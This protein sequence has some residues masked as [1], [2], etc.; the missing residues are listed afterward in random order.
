M[1]QTEGELD[2]VHNKKNVFDF[3]ELEE[4]VHNIGSVTTNIV[5]IFNQILNFASI[6]D[7]NLILCNKNNYVMY[8]K[9]GVLCNLR[10]NRSTHFVQ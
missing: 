1:Q 4:A 8:F 2:F 9:S 6:H 5:L 7:Y 3:E 10:N